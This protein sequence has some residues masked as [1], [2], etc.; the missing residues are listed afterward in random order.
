[1]N[2]DNY[3]NLYYKLCDVKILLTQNFKNANALTTITC[4]ITLELTSDLLVTT[5]LS[6]VHFQTNPSDNIITL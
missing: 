2:V 5:Q 6:L 4:G 1:M 3:Q